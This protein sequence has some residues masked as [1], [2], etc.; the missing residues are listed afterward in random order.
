MGRISSWGAANRLIKSADPHDRI[1]S[2]RTLGWHRVLQYLSRVR[3]CPWPIR[4]CAHSSCFS[5]R[6]D[7]PYDSAAVCVEASVTV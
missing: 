4:V 6:G 2:R 5:R 7:R 1:V 3:W